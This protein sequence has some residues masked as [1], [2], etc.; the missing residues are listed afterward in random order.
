MRRNRAG[1]GVRCCWWV[2]V[3]VLGMMMLPAACALVVER[4]CCS[5]M[6]HIPALFG[7]NV[8]SED[9]VGR[10]IVKVEPFDACVGDIQN[11]LR[12]KMALIVRGDCNFAWKVLQAQ[13]AHAVAVVVMDLQPR[14][15]HELWEVQMV[16]DGNASDIH[17]PSVYVSHESGNTILQG[18]EQNQSVLV[19]L[20]ATGHRTS[21]QR[22]H[23]TVLEG[24]VLYVLSTSVMFLVLSGA[25]LAFSNAASWYQRTE[26]TR[27]AKRLPVVAY[28]MKG[29]DDDSMCAI[30]L[31]PF[32]RHVLVKMLPCRHEFHHPCIDPWLEKQSSQCPLCKQD[33]LSLERTST[34]RLR[35][36]LSKCSCTRAWCYPL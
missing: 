30:C 18:L 34:F 2:V 5:V 36:R 17:I 11:D 20:N 28:E 23:H 1:Q 16:G 32:E 3:A 21:L 6:D 13:R 15:P 10:E 25:C 14:S 33:A 27:A 22:R 12:G 7:A 26:R 29:D 31:E 35:R 19:T 24:V 9:F 8:T 4:P